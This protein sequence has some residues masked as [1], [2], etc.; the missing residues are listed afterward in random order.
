MDR[1]WK[2]SNCLI[3]GKNQLL[4]GNKPDK[5]TTGNLIF[6]VLFITEFM[7]HSASFVLVMSVEL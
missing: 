4:Y 5:S 6:N 1:L 7:T 3:I 2:K